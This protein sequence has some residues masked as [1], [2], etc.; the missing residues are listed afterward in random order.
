MN[1]R[2]IYA[3]AL[4]QFYLIEGSLPRIIPLFV[5]VAV[6]ILLW[7]FF[8]RYLS[9][10]NGTSIAFVPTLLGAVLLWDFLIRV[11]QGVTTAFLEDVWSRNFL[12]LFTTPLHVSEYIAGLVVTSTLTSAVGLVVMI[13]LAALAFGLTPAA[14]GLLAL[15]FL[16][17]LFLTGLAMGVGASAM[18]FRLGPA[19]EWFVWPIPALLSP[20]V[21]VFYPTTVLPT[22][23][24]PISALLPPTYVFRA[25]R[26]ITAGKT[27]DLKH[28]GIG[29][30][31]SLFYLYL[32]S[33]SFRRTYDLAVERGL[34][35]RYSAESVN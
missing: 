28:L 16:L 29:L 21:G 27:P 1:T 13:V 30:F 32:A 35:A 3:V 2:R 19:S 5:W 4:R 34:I 22:L 8:S 11:M 14:Y 20:F 26:E 10:T 9:E 17:I 24:Q 15:P 6:D 23:M 7:G 31:L 18:V 33:R 12:N 25:V